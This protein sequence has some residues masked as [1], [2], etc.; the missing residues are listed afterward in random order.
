MRKRKYM[1]GLVAAM[2]ISVVVPAAAHATIA[3]VDPTTLI[4]DA[5]PAKQ[6]KKARG[7]IALNLTTSTAHVPPHDNLTP[8]A[9]VVVDFDKDLAFNAGRKAECSP[10]ELS[11][12]TTGEAVSRCGRAQVGDGFATTRGADGSLTQEVVSAFN[13]AAS[14][15]GLQ[16]LLHVRITQAN[17]TLVLPGNL[18]NSPLGGQY[19]KRLNVAP[20]QN[21]A[22]TGRQLETFQTTVRK[23][24]VRK[25][26]KKLA[27]G[28]KKTIKTYY[29]SARCSR[30][31]VWQFS[32]QNQHYGGPTTSAT[33][34]EACKQKK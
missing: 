12:T 11:N 8:A 24:V 18:E 5:S 9:A 33:T 19:G 23:Q 29:V 3:P 2:A 27:N 22:P 10:V 28:K 4:V 17:T 32:T 16:L 30:D 25:K 26:K 7:G 20:I 1:M 31:K 15:G 34:E 14:G 13:G 21:S 6:A